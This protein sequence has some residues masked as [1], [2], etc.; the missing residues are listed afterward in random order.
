MPSAITPASPAT[1]TLTTTG[2]IDGD[3]ATAASVRTSMTAFQTDVQ[4]LLNVTY[5]GGLRRRVVCTDNN[6]MDVYPL[7]AVLAKVSSTWTTVAHTTT[8]TID[9]EALAG[10][11]FTA[12]TRYYVYA[13]ISA[14][15]IVFSVDTTAPDAGLFYKAGDQQYQFV[16]TFFTDGSTDLLAYT[17]D[18]NYYRYDTRSSGL[19][20]NEILSNGTATIVTS[21]AVTA[22]VPTA[23]TAVQ[24]KAAASTSTTSAYSKLGRNIAAG[25]NVELT[26][27]PL[28]GIEA[29]GMFVLAG[30]GDVQYI[31]DSS[32]TH[33]YLW[34]TGF[35]Y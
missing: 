17:Q 14:G 33:T 9:P 2:P 26:L 6:T 32:S 34:V 22:A 19:T 16:T 28:M 11:S 4:A 15:A 13:S 5:G 3:L 27:F 7:G 18:D 23:A 21:V 35:W 24:F 8:S 30:T 20:G 31:N 29:N 25:E 12:D 1:V 10:G